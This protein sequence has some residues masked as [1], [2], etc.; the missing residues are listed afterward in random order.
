MRLSQSLRATVRSDVGRKR[1]CLTGLIKGLFVLAHLTPKSVP[2]FIADLIPGTVHTEDFD[3]ESGSVDIHPVIKMSRLILS[4]VLAT[5]GSLVVDGKTG[6]T[7][8]ID[9]IRDEG[10]SVK[11]LTETDLERM[12]GEKLHLA[13]AN[14]ECGDSPCPHCEKQF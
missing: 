7:A 4:N 9:V 13:E 11:T 2:P 10:H 5:S 3:E 6:F 8:L 1:I 12:V 14:R